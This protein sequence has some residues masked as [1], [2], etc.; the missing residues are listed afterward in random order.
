[1]A[2]RDDA[3]DPG[4]QAAPRAGGCRRQLRLQVLHAQGADLHV[5]PRDDRRLPREVRRGSRR[6][7]HQQRPLRLRP[8]VRR[9]ARLR[10]RRHVPGGAHL[11]RRRL[12]RVPPVRHGHARQR[13]LADR[14]A[15]PDPAR[16]V[17]TR[18]DPHEQEPA[19]RLPRLR[20]R[21]QQLGDRAPR[22]PRGAGS[23][24][25]PRRHPP[26]QPDRSRPVPVPHADRQHL[27]QRQ[28]P[29]RAREGAR[30]GGLRPLGRR[31]RSRARRGAAR[32]HRSRRLERAQRLQLDRVLVLVRQAGV[33]ADLEPR[34]REPADRPDRQHRRHAA[35]AVA[36][37]QQPRDGRV[38]GR[39]RGVRRRSRLRSP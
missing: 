3:E 38:A 33:H 2:V 13:A 29:G 20:R 24:P 23:R 17:L 28:L 22:R 1:M 4:E 36:L 30:G 9:G 34:E 10:R 32:R 16:R 7:H 12:R 18:R 15:V 26:A 8:P 39:G 11:V 6:A 25:R 21:G 14:R 31:A 35:L 19:G 5:L 27:R 37:G